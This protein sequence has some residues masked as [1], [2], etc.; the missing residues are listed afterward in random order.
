MILAF[1]ERGDTQRVVSEHLLYIK[2]WVYTKT[3]GVRKAANQAFDQM[4]RHKHFVGGQRW[5]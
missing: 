3:N 1:P 5:G 4:A 2:A